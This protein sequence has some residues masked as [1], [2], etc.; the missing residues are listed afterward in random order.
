[1]KQVNYNHLYYFYVIAKEGGIGRAAERLNVT[2]QTVSGQLGALEAYLGL[3]LFDRVGKR[4]TLNDL[5][6]LTYGYAEDIF[7]LGAE[8][9]S[10]LSGGYVG[11]QMR[12][13]VGV[14]DA[15]P[16]I[17]AFDLLKHCFS[18]D[19]DIQLISREGDFQYLLSEMA[20]N[21]LD[22]IISDRPLTPGVGVKA[23]SHPLGDS[24][25]T[26]FAE[27][28]LAKKIKG[29]FPD[30]LHG[31]DFLI[32]GD[33]SS[34]RN[35]LLSWFDEIGVRP[36]IVAEFD[37]TALMKF[38][39]QE[40]YGVFSTPTSIEPFILKQFN[41]KVLGRTE[42]VKEQYFGISPERK[43]RHAAVEKLFE[44]ARRLTEN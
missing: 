24:G 8:L 40:G 33:N 16:K 21:K 35:N 44:E 26:F 37:D 6:N 41:V 31:V 27:K 13:S 22:L 32:A 11:L 20:L 18:V 10:L 5:G 2:P 19:Q 29:A 34:S 38:F 4:L 30:C 36:R 28:R 42:E 25:I 9:S 3:Q 39:G 23:F 14:V 7:G 12:F 17:F 43:I 1:M 15:I